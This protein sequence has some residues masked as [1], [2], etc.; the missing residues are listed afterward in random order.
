MVEQIKPHLSTMIVDMPLSGTH[1]MASLPNLSSLSLL[2]ATPTD[3]H[4]R[5]RSEDVWNYWELK[6]KLMRLLEKIEKEEW[7][8][9]VAKRNLEGALDIVGNPDMW[10]ATKFFKPAEENLSKYEELVT[11]YKSILSALSE[12]E[13]KLRK[14]IEE[15]GEE[16]S[17]HDRQTPSFRPKEKV[18]E[19][20]DE[21]PYFPT[22]GGSEPGDDER[23]PDSDD[24]YVAWRPMPKM[25]NTHP[26]WV[27]VDGPRY[28]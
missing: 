11:K 19:E 22:L 9:G 21:P 17:P 6:V 3:G 15:A 10:K 7:K 8:L 5:G 25:N 13:R 24:E 28:R 23:E 27:D 4:K 1:N 12:N 20:E 26:D 14:E 18:E 2:K 16:L